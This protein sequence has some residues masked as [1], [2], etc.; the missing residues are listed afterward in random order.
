M[1][2]VS[3][4]MPCYNVAKTVDE[5]MESLLGQTH[6]DFEI[7]AVD[8]G[9]ADSSLDILNAWAAKDNRVRVMARS[10]KGIIEALNAGLQA[11]NGDYVARMDAD[12]LAHP[13]R[14]KKQA[15]FMDSHADVAVAACLVEGFPKEE[16]REG[17]RIYIDWLNSLVS[18]DEIMRELFVESPLAHPSAMFRREQILNVGGYQE[19]GW[20]EDYDLW[21]RL[22]QSGLRFAK[23]PELLLSWRDHPNRLTRTDSRY[24]VTNFLRAKAHYLMKGPLRSRDAVIIWGAGMMGKRLSKHLLDLGAPLEAFIDVDPVKIGRTRRGK[25]ILASSDLPKLWKR[26]KNPI[27]LAAVGA[28]GARALIRQELND[29]GLLEGR[30][31]WAAA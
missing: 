16:L 9:S 11:C 22:A 18:H 21:L 25:P 17:Y 1:T 15:A 13:S 31:W 6:T 2:R 19:H 26:H 29:H 20:P 4:L 3:I 8:D 30:D 23:V 10:H 28:R 14:L 7:V 12:D 5:T 24:S 27:V